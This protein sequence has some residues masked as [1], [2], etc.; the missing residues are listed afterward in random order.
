MVDKVSTFLIGFEGDDT[1][2]RSLLS[3]LR[4]Q[5]KSAISD[6]EA[7][8]K[9]V[10]LFGDIEKNVQT[11]AAA[12]TKAKQEVDTLTAAFN[13]LKI[14]GG[15][16]ATS[17]AVIQSSLKSAQAEL[18]STTREFDRSAASL[19][20]LENTLTR[21]GIDTKNLAAEEIRLEDAARAANVALIEQSSKALLGFK[22]LK[23]IQPQINQLNAAFQSL[24]DSGKLSFGELS[25]AQARLQQ[26]VR[27]LK[28]EATGLGQAFFDIRGRLIA[29]AA[30]F[31]GITHG[32]TESAKNFRDF[33]QQVAAVDSIADTTKGNI[34]KLADGVRELAKSLGVDAVESTRALYEIIS[35]GIPQENALTVLRLA[36]KAAIAG[37]TDVQTAAAVG[38]AVLN[39]YG[40]QITELDHVYDVLFQTVKDGVVTFP[41]LAKNIGTVI[42]AARAAKVPIEELGA[43]FVVLTRQGFDAPEAATAIN[44]AIIDLSAP[45]PESAE[46]LR[47][48]GIEIKGLTGTIEQLASRNFNL[49]QIAQIIP[50]VRAQRA[51]LAL[52]NNFKLLRDELGEMNKQAGQ[53]QAAY[54]KLA[55]TPQQQVAKFNAAVK[56]LSI[57][58][59]EF[60]TNSSGGL[61]TSLTG[62]VNAFNAL[63]P[64]TK[65]A[66]I[67]FAAIAIGGAALVVI[68]K[69]L[70]I[71][72]NLLVGAMS[73]SGTGA[74]AAIEGLTGVALA[75]A[76]LKVALVG[77]LS[78][79]IGEQLYENF[80]PVRKIGDIIGTLYA[81]LVNLSEF[82]VTRF[83]AFLTGNTKLAN[84][85]TA[86]FQ[87]NRDVLRDQ[88]GLA[89]SGASERLR[90]LDVQQAKLIDNLGKSS[91]AAV[92]AAGVLDT[93]VSKI[94]ASVGVQISGLDVFITRLQQRLTQLSATLQQN[95]Q[96]VQTLGQA[97]IAKVNANAAAQLAALDT[98]RNS[99]LAIASQTLAIQT[100]QAA[101]R[102]AAIQKE[103]VDSQKAFEASAQ[104]RVDIAKRTGEDLKRV[105][106]DIALERRTLLQGI[107]D[108]NRA[109]VNE[110]IGQLTG[111]LNTVRDI[112]LKRVGFNQDAEEKIRGIRAATLSVFD[113]Y[114]V[115]VREIDRLI[116]EGRKALANGDA[117]LAEDYSK[118]AIAATGEI[119]KAVTD[120]QNVVVSQSEA[121][122]K[123]ISKIRDAADLG[124]KALLAQGDAA[125][126]GA[127]KTKTALEVAQTELTKVSDQLGEVSKKLAEGIQLSIT[128][129]TDAVTKTI[130]ELDVK[131]GEQEHLMAIKADVTLAQVEIK[132]L[133]DELDQGITVN[134]KGR[135][136]EIEAAL[137]RVAKDAPELQVDVTKAL[138]AVGEVKTAA[139]AIANIHVQI[140][141]NA[142]D[143]RAEIDSLNN[144]DTSSTHTIYVRRVE[145]NAAGGPVGFALGGNV[146]THP[147]WRKVPGV[148]DRDTVPAALPVGAYVLRKAAVAKYGDGLLGR[149]ARGYAAGGPVESKFPENYWVTYRDTIAQLRE[150]QEKSVGGMRE[151]PFTSMG[152]WAGTMIDNFVFFSKD[153]REQV[154]RLLDESF[155]GWLQGIYAAKSL[156]IPL[157]MEMGLTALLGRYASGGMTDTVPAMLTPGEWVIAPPAVAKY[158]GDFM[159]ALNNLQVPRGFLDNVLNFAPP[160]PQTAAIARFAEGGPVGTAKRGGSVVGGST[161]NLTV[162]IYTQKLDREE[163]RRSVIP[164]IDKIMKRGR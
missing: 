119:S 67:Q 17:M 6:I 156:Q 71:P 57:S 18:K 52:I 65:T 87:R 136:D 73:A 9:N 80:A 129:N 144:R 74:T 97:A 86:A 157:V 48:L 8:T 50:D 115:K 88:W 70:A 35:S 27:A 72:F 93:S 134:V 152:D 42:P 95:A 51:V 106:R 12:L 61:V 102:L 164:E 43:A 68:I 85:A 25:T 154:K 55:N 137:Q 49:S 146:F 117:T 153:H 143:V 130:A 69:Q 108:A 161:G 10:K 120:G 20:K 21:A 64:A 58:L 125:K 90:A 142:A 103:S 127:E 149:L 124:N 40:L 138:T 104:A 148:G 116:S 62:M 1:S 112:E 54:L 123:A 83:F 89:V 26:S 36:S 45:A 79:K 19:T 15:A 91:A 56:D 75:A 78:F 147:N 133:K 113:Q 151:T 96:I 81:S 100:K 77:L 34:D 7:T 118:R 122:A 84:E 16:S 159:H 39:G 37:L 59:G 82:G 5:F 131:I 145:T 135:T 11:T 46:R 107:V 121:S 23:D 114:Y 66:A 132:R 158:G 141:S 24:R 3:G 162:N 63:A 139:A 29:F 53:T 38:V 60:V 99:Q 2:I 47:A 101:E 41:E 163:V 92:N 155:S 140:E 4:S 32:V 22:G 126:E 160:R 94:A 44:R 76:G 98:L 33:A 31:A 128:A 13:S 28:T 110:L 150:L 111:Y 30:A 14:S 109:H 105:E